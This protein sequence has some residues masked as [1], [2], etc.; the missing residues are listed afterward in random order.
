MSNDKKNSV[1]KMIAQNRKAGFSYFIEED[2]EAGIVLTGS[3]V[4]SLRMGEANIADSYAEVKN[5]EAFLIN[6]HIKEYEQ[7]NRFN[8]STKQPRKL[9]LHRKEINKLMAAVQRKGMTIVPLKLYFNDQNLAKLM[10]GLGKG[11][12]IHD[13]RATVKERDWSREQ[14]R[15][16]KNDHR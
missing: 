7:A 16:L 10:I 11:K 4:K 2:F 12:K 3:E 9:L 5:G 1:Y 14:G 15:I 6:A 13:K 8:H